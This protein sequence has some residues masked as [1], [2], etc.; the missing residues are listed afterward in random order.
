MRQCSILRWNRPDV[1]QAKWRPVRVEKTRQIKNPE[2][3][4]DAIGTEMALGP[5]AD[6]GRHQLRLNP[7]LRLLL[8]VPCAVS[9]IEPDRLT[10]PNKFCSAPILPSHLSSA[11]HSVAPAI[12]LVPVSGMLS[13]AERSTS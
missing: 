3:R 6:V 10:P 2:P 13:F 5:R 8:V 1:F 9:P 7:A 4:F 11:Q 12:R